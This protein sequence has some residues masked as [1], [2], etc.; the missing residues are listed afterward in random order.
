MR[1]AIVQFNIDPNKY[2]VINKKSLINKT[3]NYIFEYSKKSFDLYCKKYNIDYNIITEPKINYEH[4]TWER[5]DLWFNDYWFSSYEN[6][7]YVDTDVFAMPWAKNI[8]SELKDETSFHRIPYWKANRDLNEDSL[9]FKLNHERV[10]QSLF[11]AGVILLNKSVI[12]ATKEIVAKY[13]EPQFTD[14]SVLLN[15]AIASSDINIK[16]IDHTFNVKLTQE[17]NLNNINFLHAFGRLKDINPTFVLN[18]LKSIY[19]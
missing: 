17:C 3:N 16:N 18:L 5:I 19:D 4:P 15:Y 8:F 12:D 11:Q 1:N 6:I 7:C 14:D 10:R 2:N 13:E 9:F